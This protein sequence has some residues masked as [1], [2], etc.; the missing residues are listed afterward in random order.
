MRVDSLAAS[1]NA[2]N[3]L[4]VGCY[5]DRLTLAIGGATAGDWPLDTPGQ[6]GSAALFLYGFKELGGTGY[7]VVFD[8][9]AAWSQEGTASA[10]APAKPTATPAPQACRIAA[11][12]LIA[13]G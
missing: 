9:V 12:D 2:T 4:R 11:A 10:P 3:H 7:K 5:D 1:P 6:P 13:P 8:N